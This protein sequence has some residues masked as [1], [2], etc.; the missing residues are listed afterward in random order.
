VNKVKSR[1]EF[2]KFLKA[3]RMQTQNITEPL[4]APDYEMI[5]SSGEYESDSIKQE[6]LE[7]V[8]EEEDKEASESDKEK[9]SPRLKSIDG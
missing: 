7:E 4:A 2:R 3:K 5:A 1:D 6:S 9:D 8:K